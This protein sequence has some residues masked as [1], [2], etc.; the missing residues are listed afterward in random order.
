MTGYDRLDDFL[1]GRGVEGF[2]A[3]EIAQRA[4]PPV[5]LWVNILPTLW[6]A[7]ALRKRFGTTIVNCGYR[8]SYHNREVGGAPASLH[9]PFNA[10]DLTPSTGT[11]MEWAAFL[12]AQGLRG[13]GGLGVYPSKNFVHIDTRGLVFG[14][15]PWYKEYP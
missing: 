12:A 8:D 5:G 7:Q 9:L 4:V 3:R 15:S 10:L 13:F 2:V 11:P 1:R 14:R 6:F